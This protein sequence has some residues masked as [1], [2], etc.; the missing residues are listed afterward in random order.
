MP[1]RNTFINFS[2]PENH[3]LEYL[4]GILEDA[5]TTT[6]QRIENITTEELHWQYKAEWNTIGALL[7]HIIAFENVF[8]IAIRE[9]RRLTEEENSRWEAGR[10]LGKYIPQLITNQPIESYIAELNESR[11]LLLQ[12]LSTKTADDL[13]RKI[14]AYDPATG[15]NLAWILYHL[16]EE[17][18][19]HRGQISILRK[20][21]KEH[22]NSMI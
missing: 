15:A 2:K 19:H 14:E 1:K 9:G 3:L 13:T 11:R 6:L 21:Y 12:T 10:K 8:G 4:L 5:R 22:S 16:A 17:E 20:L 18:V 7:S